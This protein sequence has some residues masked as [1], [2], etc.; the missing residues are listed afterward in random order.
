MEDIYSGE[1]HDPAVDLA[2][3]RIYL[4]LWADKKIW[5]LFVITA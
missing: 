2:R 1:P 3:A 5:G 4:L